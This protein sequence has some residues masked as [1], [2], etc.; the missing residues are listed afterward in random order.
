[1]TPRQVIWVTMTT[2]MTVF[3]WNGNLTV[4]SFFGLMFLGSVLAGA[5]DP[6]PRQAPDPEP[7]TEENPVDERDVLRLKRRDVELLR[8]TLLRHHNWRG[9]DA[10]YQASAAGKQTTQ[11]IQ[12]LNGVLAKRITQEKAS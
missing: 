1:M 12:V 6:R 10:D 8:N 2:L 11:I 5:F 7:S 3:M 4:W 9:T